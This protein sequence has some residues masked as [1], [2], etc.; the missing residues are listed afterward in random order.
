MKIVT[1]ILIFLGLMQSA[2]SQY[3]YIKNFNRKS[4]LP[5]VQIFSLYQDSRDYLWIGSGGGLSIYDGLSFQN[6]SLDDGLPESFFFDMIEFDQKIWVAGSKGIAGIDLNPVNEYEIKILPNS[7]IQSRVMALNHKNRI[8]YIGTRLEGLKTYQNETMK[9]HELNAIFKSSSVTRIK[10]F[11]QYIWVLYEDEGFARLDTLSHV[12]KV[13]NDTIFSDVRDFKLIDDQHIMLLH[14]NKVTL[15]NHNSGVSSLLADESHIEDISLYSFEYHRDQFYLASNIGLIFNHENKDQIIGVNEGLF[16]NSVTSVLIDREDNIWIGSDSY[17][18]N[19]LISPN[20]RNFSKRSGLNSPS[21]N[22]VVEYENKILIGT[23]E[24]AYFLDQDKIYVD[25]SIRFLD[26][27]VIWDFYSDSNVLWTATEQGLLK[28]IGDEITNVP[29]INN[30]IVLNISDGIDGEIWFCTTNGLYRQKN[31]QISKIKQ[32]EEEIIYQVWDIKHDGEKYFVATENGLLVLQDEILVPLSLTLKNVYVLYINGVNDI[33]V[34]SETGLFHYLNGKLTHYDNHGLHG[35]IISNIFKNIDDNIWVSHEDGIDLFDGNQV[36]EHMDESDG[37]IGS[38]VTTNNSVFFK[39]NSFYIGF[40]G[41]LSEFNYVNQ[42]QIIK[43][44]IYLEKVH[45]QKDTVHIDLL[46]D[47]QPLSYDMNQIEFEFITPWLKSA[48]EITYIYYLEGFER[49]WKNRQGT[50]KV[51]YNNLNYG[52]YTFYVKSI[53]HNQFESQNIATFQFTIN[54]P[55]WYNGYIIF[56]MILFIGF[57]TY[58]SFKVYTSRLNKRSIELEK[59]VRLRTKELFKAKEYIEQIVEFAAI[60]IVTVD[61][62]GNIVSWNKQ[63]EF[64]F[65]YLKN[66]IIGK[67]IKILDFVNDET[68]F[69]DIFNRIDDE[70]FVSEIEIVKQRANGSKVFLLFS[71]SLIMNSKGENTG[72]TLIFNDISQQKELQFKREIQQKM[73]GGIDAMNQLLG[74]MSHHINNSVASILSIV[75]LYEES[76]QFQDKVIEITKEHTNKINAV[77]KSLRILV[78]NLNLKTRNY[79]GSEDQV[80]DID[81]DIEEFMEQFKRKPTKK[82]KSIKK[83]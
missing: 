35:Q 43:P 73:M 41:G 31:G 66:E 10:K 2:F 13:F 16:A 37:L 51:T 23:D 59:R 11:K 62:K 7:S 19:Q 18:L 29:E 30:E 32:S 58:W 81:E 53:N 34:G 4:G 8:F 22:S 79:A 33:F 9:P 27:M 67:H 46:K 80:F 47:N 69:T 77:I 76:N 60:V 56:I 61:K 15:F 39:D 72:Y 45:A 52:S 5:H 71:A 75:Q 3:Y 65:G 64:V 24:G 74:T 48:N 57:L 83:E 49:E 78:N 70:S 26:K 14:Q 63:G 40:Y 38:E 17:G 44:H 68:P 55:F 25:E 42:L 50:P 20:I 12:T 21:I 54:P 1:Y 28:K 36:I 6:F 82:E